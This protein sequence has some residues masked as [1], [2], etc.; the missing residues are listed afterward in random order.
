VSSNRVWLACGIAAVLAATPRISQKANRAPAESTAQAAAALPTPSGTDSIAEGGRA[1]AESAYV[2]LLEQTNAQLSMRWSPIGVWVTALGVLF[3]AGAIA[4]GVIVFVQSRDFRSRLDAGLEAL[5]DAKSRLLASERR[6]AE[7]EKQGSTLIAHIN[8]RAS[9][10]L[11]RLDAAPQD[12]KPEIVSELKGLFEL[13]SIIAQQASPHRASPPIRQKTIELSSGFIRSIGAHHIEYHLVGS[14]F[15]L[16][17]DI[18]DFYHMNIMNPGPAGP[19]ISLSINALGFNTGIAR[20]SIDG[21]SFPKV[22]CRGQILATGSAPAPEPDQTAVT[23]RYA[24]VGRLS[25]YIVPGTS[26]FPDEDPP[27][28]DVLFLA[29]GTATAQVSQLEEPNR[30][31]VV[32]TKLEYTIG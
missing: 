27:V 22:T 20:A 5:D 23:G 12:V 14:G 21:A 9:E 19:P 30:R 13:R 26:G 10:A 18:G 4:A 11:S 7:L 6:I 8:E 28:F 32:V 2:K 17:G 1:R 25:G 15:D 24:L 29:F 3:A 31:T 16:A